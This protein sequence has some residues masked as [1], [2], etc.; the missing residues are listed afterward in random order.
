MAVVIASDLAKDMA[1]EPLLRGVS[2]KLERRDRLT[3]AG[4]N[5][6]GKTTLL[7]MLAGETSIDGGEIALAKGVRVALH[8]Q[9][10]PRDRGLSLHEYVL[11]GCKVQL[12]LEGEL[13]ELEQAM[14]TGDE[15]AL[16]RYSDVY[17]RFEAAGGYGW[18][19]RASGYLHGLGFTDEALGRSLSTFSGGQLTRA[20]LAR[21]LAAEPDLLL[22]DEPTNH[23]DIESLEWLE[24]TLTTLDTAIVLI[25][26][27]R[28]FL[29]TVGTAVLELEAGRGRYFKGTWHQWR[30]EQAAREMAL[31]KA[32]EKQQAEIARMESFVERFRYKATKAKQAQSRLKKLDKME[33]IERDPRDGRALGFQFAKPERTGRVIFE[34]EEGRLEVGTGA[35]HKVL[36]EDAEIWLERG[37]HVSLVGP[38]GTG[39][40]T[41]IDAL[42]GQRPLDGGTLRSGHNLK[43]GYLSQHDSE[44][45]GLGSAR[46][47]A[48][49]AGKRT[50]LP[51][52]QVR[53]LLGRFLFSGEEAEK[54]LDG[55]SGGERK[56]LALAILLSQGANVLILDEPTNHLDLESREALEDALRSF[57]GALLLVT[58]DRALLDAVGTRTVAVEHKALRSYVGG[59]AEYSRVRDERKAAGEDPMGPPVKWR[60]G[61]APA[62]ATTNGKDTAKAE[63]RANGKANGNTKANGNGGPKPAPAGPSKNALREQ[64]K[65]ERTIE[66]AEVGLKAVEEELADPAAWA[67]KYETAKST[68]K[69]TAAKRAV[70]DAYAA[71]ESHLEKTGA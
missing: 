61:G 58:H 44:L 51:P 14:A 33:R 52:N 50:G 62:K 64:T 60:G 56:R 19:D 5:G 24:Q 7:R 28:W 45:E 68:A 29:E 23:L 43:V 31:G 17:A 1:G 67:T 42:A 13:T 41:L 38:N 71:L 15:A 66:Q 40:T 30:R 2:F 59:W 35:Q 65:L 10:P 26:H 25:A 22:L 57:E 53:S 34:L 63:S 8:D 39:K 4:R 48:E 32:I 55:L 27:D 46:T 18:R 47:V 11:S 6:A 69:H 16:G 9:R 37:E 54:P 70:D 21:A 12:S 3:I 36:L 20:S 49:A